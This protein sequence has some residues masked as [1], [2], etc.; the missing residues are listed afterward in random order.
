MTDL[1]PCPW[2]NNTPSFRASRAFD[3]V[4]ACFSC[5]YE[6]KSFPSEKGAIKDW[7]TRA[8][9]KQDK[10]TV[11]MWQPYYQPLE[12]SKIN[13]ITVTKPAC[14]GSELYKERDNDLDVMGWIKHE[15]E[16]IR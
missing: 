15:V 9:P 5:S 16:L 10:K 14:L 4:I 11:T 3:Y 12:V 13:G 7:N 2:C 6:R 1:K 8:E